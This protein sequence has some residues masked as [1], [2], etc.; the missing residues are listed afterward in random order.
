MINEETK[1][2]ID[3]FLYELRELTKGEMLEGDYAHLYEKYPLVRI[4][5]R[6]AILATRK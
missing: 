1:R 2:Q 6:R 4:C 3:A 5:I